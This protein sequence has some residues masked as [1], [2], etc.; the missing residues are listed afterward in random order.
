LPFGS[1]EIL[2]YYVEVRVLLLELAKLRW[3]EGRAPLIGSYVCKWCWAG[4][5]GLHSRNVGCWAVAIRVLLAWVT[6][7][8]Y[9][10]RG[11]FVVL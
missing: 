2:K 7:Q 10:G 11:D 1:R 4:L 5:A 3:G 9:I 8:Q 6:A